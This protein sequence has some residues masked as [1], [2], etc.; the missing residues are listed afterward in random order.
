MS[1]LLK[2]VLVCLVM[3]IG[4]GVF[5]ALM[6]NEEMR[7]QLRVRYEGLR[8]ALPDSTQLKQTGQ[9]VAER[10][11]QRADQLKESVQQAATKVRGIGSTPDDLV[12]QSASEVHQTEQDV[13]GT[14]DQSVQ[15]VQQGE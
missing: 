4:I 1:R 5:I 7:R 8:N 3:G 9:Q 15:P 2:G 14:I 11:S 6:R 10:I 12:H 13:V